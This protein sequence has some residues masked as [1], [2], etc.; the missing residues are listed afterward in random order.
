M[1]KRDDIWAGAALG[2]EIH[3]HTF[4]STRLCWRNID[5][6]ASVCK[7]LVKNRQKGNCWSKRLGVHAISVLGPWYSSEK[8][9]NGYIWAYENNQNHI[10]NP[11]ENICTCTLVIL[12]F[13][14]AFDTFLKAI[15]LSILYI[16]WWWQYEFTFSEKMCE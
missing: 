2:Y 3:S 5:I 13:L 1:S 7:I 16:I 6:D 10:H 15:L 14:K 12:S 9:S 11:I 4:W 8:Y